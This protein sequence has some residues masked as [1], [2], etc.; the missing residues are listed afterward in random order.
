[1]DKKIFN[2]WNAHR[3]TARR[4]SQLY[5]AL[6]YN[7]HLKGFVE[8]RIFTGSSKAIC[9]PGL[10]CYSC[11]G[12]VGACPLGALQNALNAAGHTAP[13]YMLGI[14]CLYGVILGRT[15]CGWFCPIGLLQ[16]LLHKIPTPKI[17]KGRTTRA[18]SYL[19]YGILLVFVIALPIWYGVT[20]GKTLPG[21]CK[22]ICPA[23]TLEGA[24]GL[25]SNPRNETSFYQLKLL[26]TGKWVIMLA[27]GLGCVFCWRAFCRFLCPLGAIYGL[28]NRFAF[29]GVKVDLEK[30]NGCG[31]C[32][33]NCRMDVRHVGDHEC[34]SCGKC[35][36]FCAQGAIALKCGSLTLKGPE[37]GKNADPESAVRKRRLWGRILWTIAV[38]ALAALLIWANVLSAPKSESM[39]APEPAVTEA[40]ADPA[41]DD[42]IGAEV[43]QHLMDFSTDTLGGGEFR[44]SD[45]RGKVVVITLWATYCAPCVE[46]LPFFDRLQAEHPDSLAVLAIHHKIGAKKAEKYLADKGWDHIIFCLDSDEKNL[47][48]IVNGSETMPQ[49]IVLNQKGEVIYNVQAPVTYEQ[50]EALYAQAC[51]SEK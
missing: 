12:A 49:T 18:L 6:L 25:L 46:E 32:V 34:I 38:L 24:V 5:A 19:K 40:P 33:R 21:F 29:T 20:Q 23:G 37:T 2:W 17:K 22:Y 50:L 4:L 3:P 15:V 36:S 11:P 7:A 10:N 45:W 28:F 44:L 1:M 27:V 35:I 16:E 39:P 31:A 14:L 43:G 51:V 30:C 42:L 8:G 41:A 9:V 26:F 13:W 47:F 48:G